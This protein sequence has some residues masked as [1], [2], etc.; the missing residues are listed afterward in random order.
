TNLVNI[1]GTECSGTNLEGND[2]AE[3]EIPCPDFELDKK[4]LDPS[5]GE[6][7]DSADVYPGRPFKFNITVTNTGSSTIS[8][9]VVDT[10]P[11]SVEYINATP[12]PDSIAG[13]VLT[14]YITLS[15]GE[16]AYIIIEVR[17]TECY[18][19][20]NNTANAYFD[21]YGQPKYDNASFCIV[22]D[23]NAPESQVDEI[24]SYWHN[25]PFTV[26]ATANDDESG[27][28]SVKLYY[29]YSADNSTWGAWTYF[30][31][32]TDGSDGWSWLFS[33]ADGYYHFYSIAIDMVGNV[34]PA[35]VMYDAEAGIDTV[36]PESHVDSIVPYVQESLPVHLSVIAADALSGIKD[37]SIYYRYSEDNSTWGAWMPAD[38]AFNAPNGSGYYQ[39]Y[40]IAEDVAG[41]V[42]SAPSGY[43]AQ[44]KVEIPEPLTAI[45]ESITHDGD[46]K[47]GDTFH[48][49]GNATGGVPPY[50]YKWFF[51]DGDNSTGKN[52]D[53]VYD[54]ACDYTVRLM[55]IDSEGH[56][57]NATQEIVVGAI[58]GLQVKITKP[59]KGGVYFRDKELFVLPFNISIIIGPITIEANVTNATGSAQ[60][61]FLINNDSKA[62]D[63]TEPYNYTYDEKSIGFYT[64]KAI[65]KDSA[66]RTAEDSVSAL[67]INLKRTV[68]NETKPGILKGKVY[69]NGTILKKGIA[70]AKVTVLE[71][72]DNTTTGKWLWKKGKYSLSLPP[73]NYTVKVEAEGYATKVISGV[74]IV[75]GK[76]TKLNIA[77]DKLTNETKPG[78]LAGKVYINGT[79]LKKGIAG[80]K[81]TVLETGDNTTTSSHFWNKG[82]YSLTLPPGNYT[83][84]IEAEGYET[85]EISGVVVSSGETTKL[86]VPMDKATEE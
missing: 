26:T 83:V 15:A 72:G 31:K 82:K 12:T 53:H 3:I 48:F 20:Y 34:E 27:V 30:G 37:Y 65:A 23:G 76:T 14:W 7:A 69:I 64:I 16:K 24:S 46:G 67:I 50:T 10:L 86:D 38:P 11:D 61:E 18:G 19:C 55:V 68:S 63:S 77:L 22:N 2:T 28:G 43:D 52:V 41:N 57:D 39:F 54:T 71:T 59:V 75:S 79:K 36:P 73:G 4:I 74:Q 62:T 81:V 47:V 29:S 35:P 8:L 51:G 78:T 44:C 6:W 60:V 45:I 33:G 58:P 85:V 13:Q 70:G 66:N 40:S 9:V 56:T 5:T 17:A 25:A 42:E 1:T 32:D 49:Y 84:R 80:A 21:C